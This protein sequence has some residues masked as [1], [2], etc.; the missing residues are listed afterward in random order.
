MRV[1]VSMTKNHSFVAVTESSLRA[2]ST[3]L[4]KA[5]S[6]VKPDLLAQVV[7]LGMVD[8]LVV[9]LAEV[10]K[11]EQPDK[12]ALVVKPEAVDLR[13]QPDKAVQLD[14]VDRAALHRAVRHPR[15]VAHLHQVVRLLLPH[16][17]Q[18]LLR[19]RAQAQPQPVLL[20][21]ADKVDQLAVTLAV[22][23]QPDKVDLLVTVVLLE[24]LEVRA[25]A[26]TLALAQKVDQLAETLVVAEKPVVTSVVADLLVKVDL[27]VLP[28]QLAKV[29]TE[30]MLAVIPA[31]EVPEAK[32]V[33]TK[34]LVQFR[35]VK[36]SDRAAIPTSILF[37]RTRCGSAM[38][39]TPTRPRVNTARSS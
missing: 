24:K 21:K 26:E 3:A 33:R 4:A 25:Q 17:V 35:A 34:I 13:A 32:V 23:V 16:P 18:P 31:A 2:I 28:E 11:P 36:Y 30:A 10:V 1:I 6:A 15:P 14:K 5:E 27:L 20:A 39:Q 12:A 22:A 19:P 7:K 38:L 37:P 29:V 9:T 8:L